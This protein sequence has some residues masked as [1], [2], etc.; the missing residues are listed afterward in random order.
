M[1]DVGIRL[2]SRVQNTFCVFSSAIGKCKQMC[3]MR[4]LN[5]QA[6][7]DSM[8]IRQ[9]ARA[10]ANISDKPDLDKPSSPHAFQCWRL[11]C[12]F[13]IRGSVGPCCMQDTL[14]AVCETDF[15]LPARKIDTIR[16]KSA[17]YHLLPDHRLKLITA[18]GA[19]GVQ[20]I[21]SGSRS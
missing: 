4:R 17:L 15:Q 2:W 19:Y 10:A 9:A 11:Q 13:E 21:V 8:C 6:H 1:L 14:Q 3:A 18:G 5:T 12:C 16:R 7:E 20:M